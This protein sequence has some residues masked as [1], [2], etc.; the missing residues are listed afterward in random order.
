[1]SKHECKACGYISGEEYNFDSED[2]EEVN[3]GSR[4]FLI[5][6]GSF[7]VDNDGLMEVDIYIC[8]ECGTL[9]VEL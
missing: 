7:T 4:K 8:L 3:P 9:K 5:L 2:M 1:M 6:N